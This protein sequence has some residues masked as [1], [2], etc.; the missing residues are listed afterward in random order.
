MSKFAYVALCGAAMSFAVSAPSMAQDAAAMTS[1][2][3]V[4]AEEATPLPPVVVEAPSQPLA[5]K[6]KQ[7]KSIGSAGSAPAATAPQQGPATVDGSGDGTGTAG[8]GIYTLGQ[9]DLIGGSTITN[10]AMWTFNKNSLDKAVSILPGVHDA[11]L[12]RQPQRARH[13]RARL[14]PLPRTA[15]H[16]RGAHHAASGQPPRFQPLPDAGSLRGAGAKG[17]CLSAQRAGRHGRRHQPCQPQA[18]QG[19]GA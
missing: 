9:L 18:D 3:D 15:L 2:G 17:L 7:Q 5:R 16:G 12:R 1:G 11:E 6:R 4:T 19:I 8:V 13:L 14:R 10:E